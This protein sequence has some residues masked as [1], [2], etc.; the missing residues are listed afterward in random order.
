MVIH[1]VSANLQLFTSGTQTVDTVLFV[2]CSHSLS[3]A[4]ATYNKKFKH[5]KCTTNFLDLLRG[6]YP[7]HR[8]NELNGEYINEEALMLEGIYRI[9]AIK[10]RTQLVAT[11]PEGLNEINTA[12]V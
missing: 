4:I 6:L 1:L 5:G 2:A 10:C 7:I 12:L 3:N 11:P 8:S 9:S